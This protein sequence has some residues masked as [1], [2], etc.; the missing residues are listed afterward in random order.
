[1]CCVLCVVRELRFDDDDDHDD[2][3]HGQ[4]QQRQ[5]DH[6]MYVQLD[7]AALKVWDLAS[8]G[9]HCPPKVV[10]ALP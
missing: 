1:M 7:F 6:V 5:D 3:D 9:P 2:D 10:R 4:G 8:L